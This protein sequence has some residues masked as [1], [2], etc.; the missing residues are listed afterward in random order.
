VS[1]GDDGFDVPLSGAVILGGPEGI[2]ETPFP[3]LSEPAPE[4]PAPEEERQAELEFRRTL[5]HFATG[6]TL[7]TALRGEQVYGMTA[8][9][10]MSVSLHPPLV[11][12]AVTKKARIHP[13]LHVG[14]AFGVSV[15]A[16]EQRPLSEHFG[17]R[18]LPEP[19][20]HRFEVVAD[21]PLVEGAIAHLVARVVRTYW[22]GDHSLFLGQ[23]EYSRWRTGRPLIFHRGRYRALPDAGRQ[24]PSEA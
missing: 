12:V 6:V 16:H 8:N 15:L 5:G 24:P 4:R 19:P 18:P 17:G 10:F 22:G 11:L 20:P 21:T 3:F 7:I 23:V 9:A 13:V 2:G 14:G 1:A